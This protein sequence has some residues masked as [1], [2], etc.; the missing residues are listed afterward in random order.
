MKKKVFKIIL[1]LILIFSIIAGVLLSSLFAPNIK[2]ADKKVYID[3]PEHI[4][5]DSLT[6][7]LSPYLQSYQ[8]FKWAA[9]IKRFK[10]P[11]AGRYLLKNNMNNNELINLLRIGKRLEVN[12][13]FNNRNSLPELA[14]AV[15]R[16]IQ[17]D[18]LQLL[19]SMRDQNFIAQNGFTPDNILLMYI[20]NTYRMYYNTTSDKFRN[21]MLNEYHKFWNKERIALAKKQGLNPIEAGILASIVQKE[22]TKTSELP[23]I[24][25][26]YLN[27]LKKNMLLQADPTVVFAYKQKYGKD[28]IIKRVLNKHKAVESPYN[29]YKHRGLPPGPICMPDIQAIEAVLHPEKHNYLYFVADFDKPGYHIFS[30]NLSEHNRHAQTYHRNLNRSGIYH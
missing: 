27:R 2:T 7:I 24:A 16:Q 25:G 4:G 8:Q 30:Q 3:V 10:H 1:G 29:T 12:L 19:Q 17:P 5:I 6:H 15:S 21:K 9:A 22:S 20:P 28:L 13:T 11:K 18:S 26:V 14:G 23:R